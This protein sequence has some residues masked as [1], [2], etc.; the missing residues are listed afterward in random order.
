MLSLASIGYF[1]VCFDANGL[2]AGKGNKFK[3]VFLKGCNKNHFQT[4][5]FPNT[6]SPVEV[7]FFKSQ[8]KTS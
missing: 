4:L 1:V 3:R 5:L 2:E 7:K 6:L 8:G